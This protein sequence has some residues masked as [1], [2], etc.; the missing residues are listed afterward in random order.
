MNDTE[1]LL[2]V[3]QYIEDSEVK[4]DSEW[5]S[6]RTVEQMVAANIMPPLYAEVLRRLTEPKPSPLVEWLEGEFKHALAHDLMR[7]REALLMMQV[8]HAEGDPHERIIA[9][10]IGTFVRGLILKTQ[11]I[12][13]PVENN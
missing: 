2:A 3:K 10:A 13:A 5:G 6:H 4:M 9:I 1:F 12:T 7:V 8:G 11:P